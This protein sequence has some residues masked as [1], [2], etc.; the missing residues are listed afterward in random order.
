MAKSTNSAIR[1]AEQAGGEVTDRL[2]HAV[3]GLRHEIAAIAAAVNDY[4]SP[5]MRE[6]QHDLQQGATALAQDVQ[7]QLPLVARRVS[8]QAGATT[9]AVVNDPVPAIVV[10]GTLALL[11]SLF[12]S[13]NR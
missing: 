4:G 1:A 6:W 12:A 10:V 3:S 13:R 11:V 5:R 9:R 2:M 7:R 8:R